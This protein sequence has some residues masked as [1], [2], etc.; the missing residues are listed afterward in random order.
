[1]RWHS[2]WQLF[3]HVYLVRRFLHGNQIG[4]PLP[5]NVSVIDGLFTVDLDFWANNIWPDTVLALKFPG[6]WPQ[7]W[8]ILST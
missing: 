3:V 5:Q 6:E 2:D 1:M 4:S 7:V 8:Q